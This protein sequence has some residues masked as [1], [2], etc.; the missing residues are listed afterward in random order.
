MATATAAEDRRVSLE[1][2][3][4]A[5][6]TAAQATAGALATNAAAQGA[7]LATAQAGRAAAE[8]T[9]A[10]LQTA[11]AA[12]TPP[13]A[14]AM[15]L[16][17]AADGAAFRT[18]PLP[19]GWHID[20]N[21][22]VAEGTAFQDYVNLPYRTGALNDYAVEAEIQVVGKTDCAKNF[23]ILLRGTEQGFYAGGVEWSCG[24]IARLWAGQR[25]IGSQN[26]TLDE[27]WHTYRLEAKGDRI[28]VSIDGTVVIETVDATSPIGSQIA[29][30]SNGVMFNVRAFRVL[31][32]P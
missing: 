2:T 31:R 24:P 9:V 17:Q 3:T 7:D 26:L 5:G 14:T 1:A 8:A 27:G 10:A 16:Y 28:R 25:A 12:P 19:G 18:W 21:L 20:G 6:V 15:V 13:A 32:L 22:L 4:A 11:G 23:G 29:L 30:W